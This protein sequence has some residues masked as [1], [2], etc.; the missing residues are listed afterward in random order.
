MCA[1]ASGDHMLLLVMHRPPCCSDR[2][3]VDRAEQLADRAGAL[4]VSGAVD[5]GSLGRT[6]VWLD[7]G[8]GPRDVTHWDGQTTLRIVHRTAVK[9]RQLE[10]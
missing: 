4:V 3:K 8:W 10:A 5:W 9:F 7:L 2:G 6:P 1:G